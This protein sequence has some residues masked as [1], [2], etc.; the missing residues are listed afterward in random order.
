[1]A[2]TDP[3]DESDE[4]KNEL[5]PYRYFTDSLDYTSVHTICIYDSPEEFLEDWQKR[6]MNMEKNNDH[7]G[8]GMWYWVEDNGVLVCSGAMDPNDEDIFF[9][10][11]D[12]AGA[13]RKFTFDEEE[14]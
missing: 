1:M 8:T 11:M 12:L 3:A 9:D 14:K 7:S 5:D 13:V 4:D 2:I 6:M 10:D